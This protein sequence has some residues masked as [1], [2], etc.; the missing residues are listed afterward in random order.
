[1]EYHWEASDRAQSVAHQQATSPASS[2]CQACTNTRQSMRTCSLYASASR[3]ATWLATSS[4]LWHVAPSS[5]ACARGTWPTAA[6]TRPTSLC[7]P[8]RGPLMTCPDSMSTSRVTSSALLFPTTIRIPR[9]LSR[10]SSGPSRTRERRT[11][12]ALL[13]S[14]GKRALLLISSPLPMFLLGRSR[15]ISTIIRPLPVFL[16][17]R[18]L[19]ICL[20]SIALRLRRV[21]DLI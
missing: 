12:S 9:F 8:S 18:G 2:S 16:F 10:S 20:L 14:H 5:R 13:C 7:T 17:S 11:S 19:K 4:R 21:Y 1:M 15:T 6:I 3:Q